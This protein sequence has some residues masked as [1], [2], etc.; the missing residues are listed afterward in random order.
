MPRAGLKSVWT[1]DDG[2]LQI[3]VTARRCSENIMKRMLFSLPMLGVGLVLV[4]DGLYTRFSDYYPE[5]VRPF[6]VLLA[7]WGMLLVLL[8]ALVWARPSRA[9]LRVTAGA[10]FI[11]IGLIMLGNIWSCFQAGLEVA[12]SSVAITL[13]V[14]LALAAAYYG[15]VEVARSASET[16]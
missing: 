9:L 1:D 2:M 13:L 12:A 11:P 3:A 16:S 15:V 8:L 14:G 7:A 6:G 4:S 5:P 10:A